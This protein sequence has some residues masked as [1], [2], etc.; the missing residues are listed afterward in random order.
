MGAETA[1][2]D[3]SK[4]ETFILLMRLVY[5][6]ELFK[7]P[8]GVSVFGSETRIMRPIAPKICT[9]NDVYVPHLNSKIQVSTFVHFKVKAFF[10]FCCQIRIFFS[11]KNI[12]TFLPLLPNSYFFPEKNI[13]TSDAKR[14]GSLNN[15][16]HNNERLGSI[17]N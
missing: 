10:Y 5:K 2:P 6:L 7:P 12:G 9:K 1:G 11:E 3:A 13:G 8:I 16:R 17:A 14:R 15:E 4:F